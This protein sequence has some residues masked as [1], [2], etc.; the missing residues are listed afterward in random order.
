[1]GI[2]LGSPLENPSHSTTRPLVVVLS[3]LL[4][5]MHTK[6]VF[7]SYVITFPWCLGNH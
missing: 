2:E 1:M 7:F 6:L 5:I 4:G 3:L